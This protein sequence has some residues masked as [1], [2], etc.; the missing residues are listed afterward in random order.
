MVMKSGLWCCYRS[1]VSLVLVEHMSLFVASL[2]CRKQSGTLGNQCRRQSGML[3]N[4]CRK[5]LGML[6][7]QCRKQ[8]GTLGNQCRK[9]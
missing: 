4:Q 2:Q 5:Q 7:N 1:G 9:Q 3:G 8:S 6:G